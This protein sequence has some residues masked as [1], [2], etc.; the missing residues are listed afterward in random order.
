ML[1]DKKAVRSSYKVFLDSLAGKDFLAHLLTLEA[2][3]QGLGIQ[4]EKVAVKAFSMERMGVYYNLRT[5][6]A[7]MSKPALSQPVRSAGSK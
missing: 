2:T 1:E 3:S 4:S 6:L 5:Y 7:D